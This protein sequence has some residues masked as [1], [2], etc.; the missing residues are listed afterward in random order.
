MFHDST[1]LLHC[2]HIEHVTLH[3]ATNNRR[4]STGQLLTGA[5]NHQVQFHPATR[6]T[7]RARACSCP[8][9]TPDLRHSSQQQ[10]RWRMASRVTVAISLQSSDSVDV[11]ERQPARH[12]ATERHISGSHNGISHPPAKKYRALNDRVWR[13]VAAYGH[14]E[15]LVYLRS[16]AH[17]SHS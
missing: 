9:H 1:L 10:L 4:Q 6:P 12:T 13:A 14:A 11:Y 7:H 5:T 16:I 8:D 17:L 15:I 2:V 3:R